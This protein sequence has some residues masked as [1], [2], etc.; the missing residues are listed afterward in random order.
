MLDVCLY[1][2][3]LFGMRGWTRGL[4]VVVVLVR[5]R[6][7]LVVVLGKDTL[8]PKH[9]QERAGLVHS[10][11]GFLGYRMYCRFYAISVYRFCGCKVQ[12]AKVFCMLCFVA[13]GTTC[14]HPTETPSARGRPPRGFVRRGS[15]DRSQSI[16][17]SM[18]RLRTRELS[19]SLSQ[20]RIFRKKKLGVTHDA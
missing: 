17:F 1:W 12:S 7:I 19:Q 10:I 3:V 16:A 4:V 5:L 13:G 11:L 20:S 6:V 2:Q 18:V 8:S 15:N 9:R 14:D